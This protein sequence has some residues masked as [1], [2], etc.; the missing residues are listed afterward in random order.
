MLARWACPS[1]DASCVARR[2]VT[3]GQAEARAPPRE[4][5]AD[6]NSMS[7][8]P[9]GVS[10]MKAACSAGPMALSTWAADSFNAPSSPAV[11]ITWTLEC[12]PAASKCLF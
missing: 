7:L 4:G 12:N 11:A 1:I 9:M 8:P 5:T 3:D 2:S 6:W 10:T